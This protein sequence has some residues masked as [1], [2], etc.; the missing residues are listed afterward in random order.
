[1]SALVTAMSGVK[2]IS[3]EG[4]KIHLQLTIC[5]P[6]HLS[7]GPSTVS[8]DLTAA[9]DP[10]LST[11]SSVVLESEDIQFED[12]LSVSHPQKLAFL[13]SSLP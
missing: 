2:L 7:C 4:G 8:Y 11:I 1:M 12:I 3:A 10:I 5:L 13:V 6:Q 9:V